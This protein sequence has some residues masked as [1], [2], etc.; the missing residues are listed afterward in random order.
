MNYN[1]AD[2]RKCLVSKSWEEKSPYFKMG[3]KFLGKYL[4]ES[5]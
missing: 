1:S 4:N 2:G 5:V 3:S